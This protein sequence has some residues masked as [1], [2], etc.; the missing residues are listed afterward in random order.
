MASKSKS[1]NHSKSKSPSTSPLTSP[2]HSKY[3]NPKREVGK[4]TT[5]TTNT[6]ISDKTTIEP[7][8]VESLIHKLQGFSISLQKYKISQGSVTLQYNPSHPLTRL[9]RENFGIEPTE[10]PIPKRKRVRKSPQG[11]DSETLS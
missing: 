7:L 6:N 2:S 9:Q 10:L 11:S 4:T 8:E 1:K 3:L 5:T